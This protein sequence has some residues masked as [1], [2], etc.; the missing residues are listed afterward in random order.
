[1]S[2]ALILQNQDIEN[3]V[4]LGDGDGTEDGK[5]WRFWHG[6]NEDEK[7]NNE[8]DFC[9]NIENIIYNS[10]DLNHWQNLYWLQSK[11]FAFVI[12]IMTG[13]YG[14]GNPPRN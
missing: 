5:D 8:I 12:T 4:R 2:W 10:N 13:S 3:Q 9:L 14:F 1:M 6:G 11:M 7:E